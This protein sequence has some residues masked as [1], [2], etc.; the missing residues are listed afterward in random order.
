MKKAI[1]A[2]AATL[3]IG[4]AQ[5]EWV[6]KTTNTQGGEIVLTDARLKCDNGDYAAYTHTS[7]G[8]SNWGCYFITDGKVFMKWRNSPSRI[9]EFNNGN[10][11]F[12]EEWLRRIKS[13]KTT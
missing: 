3:A 5:A 4:S 2:V 7:T 12:N 10:W 11:T 9:Y 6:A 1:I 13:R 8:E